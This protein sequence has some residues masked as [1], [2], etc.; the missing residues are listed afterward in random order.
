MSYRSS[1]KGGGS[2]ENYP[3]QSILENIIHTAGYHDSDKPGAGA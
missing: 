1:N 2:D 3:G